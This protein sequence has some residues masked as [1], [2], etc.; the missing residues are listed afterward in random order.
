MLDLV[1]FV[2]LCEGVMRVIVTLTWNND[3][4]VHRT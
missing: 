1:K 4:K 3:K 2:R